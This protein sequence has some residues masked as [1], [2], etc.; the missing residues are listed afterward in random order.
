MKFRPQPGDGEP[1]PLDQ[2]FRDV[3]GGNA[4]HSGNHKYHETVWK[5]WLGKEGEPPVA[6]KFSGK[7]QI[8]VEKLKPDQLAEFIRLDKLANPG[9]YPTNDGAGHKPADGKGPRDKPAGEPR[10]SARKPKG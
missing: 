6:F 1:V 10:E 8:D 5:E 9:A 7:T 2:A 3:K 4:V